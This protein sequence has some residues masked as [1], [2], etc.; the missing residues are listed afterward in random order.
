MNGIAGGVGDKMKM[1][2]GHPLSPGAGVEKR[3]LIP[4]RRWS[5]ASGI[6]RSSLAL[7]SKQ[8][9]SP[10]DKYNPTVLISGKSVIA[11]DSSPAFSCTKAAGERGSLPLIHAFARFF[12][13]RRQGS[14]S[15][16]E[17]NQSPISSPQLLSLPLDSRKEG[18]RERTMERIE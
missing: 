8:I 13:Q 5:T 17:Q 15:I 18:V 2:P 12:R 7:F 10:P 14:G 1:K 11:G 6:D 16:D 3:R 9:S 4:V